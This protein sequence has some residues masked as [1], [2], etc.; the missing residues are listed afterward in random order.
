MIRVYFAASMIA[1]LAACASGSDQGFVAAKAVAPAISA[2]PKEGL[3]PQELKPGQCGLF[4]WGMSAP[5]MFVL[6]KEGASGNALILMDGIPTS[7]AMTSSGGDVF[8]QFMTQ[9]KFAN[10]A[11][12]QT[13]TMTLEPGQSLDGGQRVESGNLLFRNADG[14]ETILPVTGV[15]A[16][17]PG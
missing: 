15:R 16:C 1:L 8:G 9:M 6:F 10:P 17:M 11:S 14:W 3:P 7:L 2:V 13:V 5:R 4:L 12:G